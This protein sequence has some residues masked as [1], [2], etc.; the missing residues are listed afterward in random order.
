MLIKIC[1]LSS[2]EAIRA[3][4]NAGATHVGLVHFQPSPRHL[5]LEDAARLRREVPDGVKAVLLLVADD[6]TNT[7]RAI[8][9]VRPDI[10]QFHG[11]QTPE[12]ISL[13]REQAEVECWRA[14]GV[15]DRETLE[16]SARFEGAVD[17][18]LFDAPPPDKQGALPGGNGSAFD[19]SL[20]AQHDHRV[21]WGLAGGLTP[22]NVA[23]AI[24]ATNA[25]MVDASSG[26]ESAP[27]VKDVDR[28]AAFCEAARESRETR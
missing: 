20:L 28:I 18:L 10:V 14:V 3:S 8:E 23:A 21:P 19:W 27:G 22:D 6:I 4:V 16:K 24:R 12:W 5:E 17:R 2:S 15:R 9:M 1:G 11:K 7:G 13:V 26:V 25:P